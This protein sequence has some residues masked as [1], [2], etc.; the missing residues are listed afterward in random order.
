MAVLLSANDIEGFIA[1]VTAVG[2]CLLGILFA[3]QNVKRSVFYSI[4]NTR[5]HRARITFTDSYQTDVYIRWKRVTGR[6]YS[7]HVEWTDKQGEMQEA[8]IETQNPLLGKYCQHAETVLIAEVRQRTK[9]QRKRRAPK[10]VTFSPNPDGAALKTD[11]PKNTPLKTAFRHYFGMREDEPLAAPVPEHEI[12]FFA[13]WRWHKLWS[14]FYALMLLPI[15]LLLA[16][17]I[18][19]FVI[20][21]ILNA[22]GYKDPSDFIQHLRGAESA[23]VLFSSRLT[24]PFPSALR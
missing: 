11:V 14:L 5:F 13:Q 24:I 15:V 6:V 20:M 16:V 2:L 18:L 8:V 23:L 10:P 21:P 17:L 9:K 12:M 3:V 4:W 7:V 1:A 19:A 22:L